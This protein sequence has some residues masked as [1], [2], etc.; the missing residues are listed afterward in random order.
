[1][2][3]SQWLL[4]MVVGAIIFSACDK[5]EKNEFNKPAAYWYQN[6]VK[7]IKFGNLEGADNFYASLQSEHI[8]SPLLPDAMLILGQAHMRKEEYLLAEFYLDE[9][10]KRFGNAQNADYITY[11]KLQSRYYGIKNSSKRSRIFLR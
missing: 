10:L 8:N 11:L 5:K 6:I 2:R 9:Y 4:P 1:M 3:F 7:E